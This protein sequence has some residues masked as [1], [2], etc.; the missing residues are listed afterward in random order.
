MEA[1][2]VQIFVPGSNTS[3]LSSAP[4]HAASLHPP[5]TSSFPFASS[6]AVCKK[7]A[8]FNGATFVQVIAA[9]A[10]C[11]KNR[12]ISSP[13]TMVRL[14]NLFKFTGNE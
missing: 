2:L 3:A 4:E 11:G 5:V 7:R 6:V 12:P 1:T 9:L 8:V 13:M 14:I 10:G